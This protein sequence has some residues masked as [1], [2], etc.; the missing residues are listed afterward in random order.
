MGSERVRRRVQMAN[1]SY[2]DIKLTGASDPL[3]WYENWIVARARL[4]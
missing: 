4:Y 1:G 3:N 2:N